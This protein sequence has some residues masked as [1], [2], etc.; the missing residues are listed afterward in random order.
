MCI[1]GAL[2][3]FSRETGTPA[4]LDYGLSG[5]D[6]GLDSDVAHDLFYPWDSDSWTHRISP[7]DLNPENCAKVIRHLIATGEVDWSIIAPAKEE[8]SA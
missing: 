2:E 6:V 8:V 1:G 5:D 3:Q 7:E 4:D